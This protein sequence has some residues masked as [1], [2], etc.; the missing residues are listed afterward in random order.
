MPNRYGAALNSY[1]SFG[2]WLIGKNNHIY[3]GIAFSL[4]EDSSLFIIGRPD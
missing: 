1:I 4:D 3:I 2:R